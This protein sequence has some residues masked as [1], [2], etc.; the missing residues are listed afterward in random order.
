MS[1][2]VLRPTRQLAAGINILKSHA[3]DMEKSFPSYG[4]KSHIKESNR[5]V[6]EHC[7]PAGLRQLHKFPLLTKKKKKKR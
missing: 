4:F 7:L 3:L 5:A 6:A 2:V 1:T